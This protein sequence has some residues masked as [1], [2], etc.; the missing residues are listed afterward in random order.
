MSLQIASDLVPSSGGTFYL[1]EDIYVKGGIQIRESTSERDKI[2]IANLKL[3]QLVLTLADNKIW[4]V[5][6]LV[7]PSRENPDAEEKVTWEEFLT[8]SSSG[9]GGTGGLGDDAPSDGKTYGRKDGA[10]VEVQSSTGPTP[11]QPNSRVVVINTIDNLAAGESK[12]VAIDLAVS[13]IVLKLTVNRA[14]K[15]SAY[16]TSA[17][18]E[19]NP[20]QF[21]ATDD[22]LTDDGTMLLGDGSTFRSRN[23]SILANMEETPANTIYWTI[24][25]VDAFE[26]PVILT[27]TY[28]P[29]E[30]IEKPADTGTGTG[31]GTDTGTGTTTTP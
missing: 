25:S 14:V 1:M 24:E 17:R 19:P 13:S 18:D 8:G 22:H 7:V 12:D 6:E 9:G 20:Y 5:T 4:K 16:G 2:A 29:L 11:L 26:G 28:L 27:I 21:L 10:W 31:T 15:V 3:G 23:F 30:V